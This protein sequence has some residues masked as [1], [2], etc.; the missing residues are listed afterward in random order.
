LPLWQ[1]VALK[2]YNEGY[3]VAVA[4]RSQSDPTEGKAL[5]LK[6]DVTKENDII[7]AF[8]QVEKSLG[9]PPNV[10]VYNG[11]LFNCAQMFN[12]LTLI[13]CNSGSVKLSTSCRRPVFPTIYR[14][15]K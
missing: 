2:L 14:V 6:V 7:S 1:A 8:K 12:Q 4:S 5:P 15:L 11:M 13:L 9:A 3:K 10:V